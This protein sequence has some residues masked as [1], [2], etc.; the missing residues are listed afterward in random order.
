MDTFQPKRLGWVDS[1]DL[2]AWRFVDYPEEDTEEGEGE[3]D[4]PHNAQQESYHAEKVKEYQDNCSR[5]KESSWLRFSSDRLDF[6]QQNNLKVC[7]QEELLQRSRSMVDILVVEDD[8][9]LWSSKD[10][11]NP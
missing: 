8:S 5:R 9:L 6:L 3:D 10:V 2:V 7:R 11:Q 1:P 4:E